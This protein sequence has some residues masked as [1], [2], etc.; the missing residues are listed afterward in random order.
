[1]TFGPAPKASQVS[2]TGVVM[3]V[4]VDLE[5]QF[6]HLDTTFTKLK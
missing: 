1:M 3:P 4:Q 5:Q 2:K 6:G